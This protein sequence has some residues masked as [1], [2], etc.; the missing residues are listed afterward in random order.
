MSARIRGFVYMGRLVPMYFPEFEN[1]INA[2]PEDTET[3]YVRTNYILASFI[4]RH[5]LYNWFVP[6]INFHTV[7]EYF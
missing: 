6:F 2:E 3:H 1:E 7:L 4:F 5:F